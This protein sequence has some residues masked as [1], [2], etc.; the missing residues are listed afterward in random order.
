MTNVTLKRD[1]A[2]DAKYVAEFKAGAGYAKLMTLGEYV[3]MRRV[4]DGLDKLP[5]GGNA[6]ATAENPVREPTAEDLD[7]IL[8]YKNEP[9]YREQMTLGEYV[10]MRRV[11]DGKDKLGMPGT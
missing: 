10:A 9:A 3:A 5:F 2:E 8:E 6:A 7:Y 4:D 1:A 11:D